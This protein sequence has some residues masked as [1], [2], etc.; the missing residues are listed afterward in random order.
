MKMMSETTR[1]RVLLVE[2]EA[3]IAMLMQDMLSELDCD[4]V[5]TA[6]E[7]DE[8]VAAARAGSFDLAFVDLNLAGVP[9]YPVAQALRERGIPFAFVTGYGAASDAANADVPVLQKPFR[10]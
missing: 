7:L 8:A 1:T 3:L 2:D 9:A 6:G 5:E 4:V 10:G